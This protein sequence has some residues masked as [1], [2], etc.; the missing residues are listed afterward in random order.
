MIY[1]QDLIGL[2]KLLLPAV[3]WL[4]VYAVEKINIENQ[5]FNIFMYLC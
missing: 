3:L 5:R 1:K 4:E 2:K